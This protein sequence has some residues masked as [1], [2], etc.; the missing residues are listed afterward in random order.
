MG[1]FMLRFGA[2][3][4]VGSGQAYA[5][6]TA[7]AT[8]RTLHWGQGIFRNATWIDEDGDRKSVV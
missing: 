8:L 5:E 4:L 2:G 6:K 7:V 1:F 3:N